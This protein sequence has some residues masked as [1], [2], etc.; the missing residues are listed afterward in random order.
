[1]AKKSGIGQTGFMTTETEPIPQAAYQAQQI[2]MAVIQDLPLGT[3][4]CIYDV[5]FTIMAGQLL[6]TRGALIPALHASGLSHQDCLRIRSAIVKGSWSTKKLLKHLHKLIEAEQKWSALTVAG[7]RVHALDTTCVFRPRLKNCTTNHYSPIAKRAL[8]AINFGLYSA[9]G[10]MEIQKVTIPKAIVR[11]DDQANTE[12]KL[13]TAL[14]KA[15]A[16]FFKENDIITADRKFSVMEVIEAGLTNVVI[17]RAINFTMRRVATPVPEGQRKRGRPAKY[18]NRERPTARMR[19]GKAIP[20]TEPDERHEWKDEAGNAMQASVWKNVVLQPQKG[21]SDERKELNLK[22]VWTVVLVKHPKYQDPMVILMN[23]KL[24]PQESCTVMRG[25]WGVEQLPLVGKQLL[26]GHRMFV[27][28]KEM[29]FRLP[30]LIFVGAAMLMYLAGG[31][32]AIPTGKWDR[33]PKKTAGRMM[34]ELR[35]VRHLRLLALPEQLR[36]KQSATGHW[37]SGYAAVRHKRAKPTPT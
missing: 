15:A 10:F 4:L 27:H 11:G 26:G 6:Q 13:M 28:N 19:K 33:A 2:I 16:E 9:V 24:T 1:V 17:R 25:R 18:G 35:K 30:E 37:L 22:Q 23:V 36:K 14:C 21:W 31:H 29:N 3:N 7:Y 32:E 34:R 12:V 8:P 20:A 5:L